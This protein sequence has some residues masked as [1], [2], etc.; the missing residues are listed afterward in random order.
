MVK[1]KLVVGILVFLA[2][3]TSATADQSLIRELREAEARYGMPDMSLV[4]LSQTESSLKWFAINFDDGA[5]FYPETK[6]QALRIVRNVSNRPYIIRVSKN[7]GEAQVYFFR[8]LPEAQRAVTRASRSEE[9]EVFPHPDGSKVR[10][11]NLLNT[12][13]CAMQLNF[14]WQAYEQGRSVKQ[15]LD[16]EFCIDHAA[17]FVSGLIRKHGFE[18]GIGCYYTCGKDRNAQRNRAEYFARYN[19]HFKRLSSSTSLAQR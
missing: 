18:K 15:L 7:G 12:G 16:P 4:A 9:Y 6:E 8:S 19:R 3:V 11:L 5:S 1:S 14:R 2:S 10:K 13:L 17:K